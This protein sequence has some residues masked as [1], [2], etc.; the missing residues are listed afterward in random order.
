MSKTQSKLG[1]TIP[2]K[3]LVYTALLNQTST[4]A[5]VATVLKNTLGGT[6]VW[7][8]TSP[9]LYVGTLTGA[10]TANK[11]WCISINGVGNHEVISRIH[12]AN[13]NQVEIYATDTNVFDD[14]ILVDTNVEIRV[15]P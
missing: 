11:T 3:Y 10:F 4:N 12:R 14:D 15:Y 13:D 5:P 6:V 9:G 2:N 7:T 8:R 1:V